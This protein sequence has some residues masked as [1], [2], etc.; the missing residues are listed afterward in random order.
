MTPGTS[1]ARCRQVE[2]RTGTASLPALARRCDEQV[3]IGRSIR[4]PLVTARL[5]RPSGASRRLPTSRPT[6]PAALAVRTT[7]RP[8]RC[9]RDGATPGTS[10]RRGTWLDGCTAAPAGDRAADFGAAHGICRPPDTISADPAGDRSASF[11]EGAGW[12]R[13]CAGSIWTTAAAAAPAWPRRPQRTRRPR[14]RLGRTKMLERSGPIQPMGASFT[15]TDEMFA[16][17][18][19]ISR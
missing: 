9:A 6:G 15:T 1:P 7:R 19:R 5:C 2:H 18:I 13:R 17:L 8:P 16:Q 12:P 10:P 3:L 14:R 4:R 11:A